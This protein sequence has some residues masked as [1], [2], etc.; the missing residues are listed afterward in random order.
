LIKHHKIT[1]L[2]LIIDHPVSPFILPKILFIRVLKI[3]SKR[4]A[5][6]NIIHKSKQMN[7]S[8]TVYIY[9]NIDHVK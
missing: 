4:K 6:I 8:A 7:I 2:K 3:N 5:I 1:K 9:I